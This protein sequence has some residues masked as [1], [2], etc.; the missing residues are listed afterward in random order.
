MKN[1]NVNIKIYRAKSRFKKGWAAWFIKDGSNR[2]PGYFQTKAEAVARGNELVR[3]RDVDAAL[4]TDIF[5]DVA[6]EVIKSYERRHQ[7]GDVK[8]QAVLT[9]NQSKKFWGKYFSDI[10]LNSITV[11]DIE[12]ALEDAAQR[13]AKKTVKNHWAF[14]RLVFNRAVATKRVLHDMTAN[15]KLTQIIGSS[16]SKK[17]GPKKIS[18]DVIQKIIDNAGDYRL[19]IKFATKTGMR[20]GEIRALVW[21]NVDLEAGW[22][23]V[24]EETGSATLTENGWVKGLVKTPAAARNIP[25]S[26]ELVGEL[27]EHRLKSKFSKDTDLVFPNQDGGILAP[28]LL[29]GKVSYRSGRKCYS[30]AIKPAC[31][32]AKVEPIRFHDLRHHYASLQIG[33]P[34]VSLVEVANLMGHESSN[35]TETIYHKWLKGD[36]KDSDTRA[37]AAI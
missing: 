35:I 29:S 22:I 25:I 18:V 24:V 12:L 31:D 8:W 10:C 2:L 9:A 14:L 21:E 3:A 30:G 37:R 27:R 5:D 26:D 4:A 34:E 28:C 36:A 33:R 32:R 19:I 13:R 23:T 11:Q 6:D 20:G 17:A 16:K 15:V 7:N 1:V